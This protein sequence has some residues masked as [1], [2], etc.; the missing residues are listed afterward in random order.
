MNLGMFNGR[1]VTAEP[2]NDG[3]YLFIEARGNFEH[4]TQITL[5]RQ[6]EERLLELLMEREAERRP[7]C[8]KTVHSERGEYDL[9]CVLKQGHSP[10]CSSV[11]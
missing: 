9:P 11:P 6:M 8:G 3:R 1:E 4:P 7:T 5:S 10:P 2:T